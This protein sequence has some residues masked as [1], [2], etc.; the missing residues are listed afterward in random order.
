MTSKLQEATR[1]LRKVPKKGARFASIQTQ[2]A[3]RSLTNKWNAK[4]RI[5]NID[6]HISVIADL[7]MELDRQSVDLTRWS[8]SGHNFVHRRYFTTPDPIRVVNA[9]SW[10]QLD[11]N[12][13]DRFQDVYGNYLRTFD[14]FISCFSPTFSEL[15]RGI[16]KPKL[17]VAATRYEAPYSDQPDQW[18]R[19]NEYVQTE[20]K[21]ERM[22]LNTNNRGDQDYCEFFLGFKPQYVPSVCDYTS[23]SWTGTSGL[24][25]IEAIDQSF[26]DKVVSET[27]H[28]WADSKKILGPRYSWNRVGELS[29]IFVLPYNVSTMTLFELATAGVPVSVPSRKYL[30]DLYFEKSPGALSQLTW[31]QVLNQKHPTDSNNPNDSERV[32]FLDWWLD[33]CD[34]YDPKLMPNVRT[35]DSI[36][37][38]INTPH[39]V[40]DLSHVE[41][42]KIVSLRNA[43]LVSRRRKLITEFLNLML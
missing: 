16:D 25:V 12:M 31:F 9:N 19:F 13:I 35:V 17:V 39:P 1:T 15:F 38:L 14:G 36:S 10:K 27:R 26:I 3:S 8:I 32:T 18:E 5:F 11:E 20:V 28:T 22:I 30:K 23:M 7:Q 40:H 37:E 43:D 2:I 4:P 21:A 41:W 29:E 34:F 24:K 33:R 6:L 42:Q